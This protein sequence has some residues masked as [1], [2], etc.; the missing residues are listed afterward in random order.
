MKAKIKLFMSA[1]IVLFFVGVFS[2]CTSD[3][4][5][6]EVDYDATYDITY[7]NVDP[8]AAKKQW[9]WLGDEYIELKP[10]VKAPYNLYVKWSDEKGKEALEFISKKEGVITERS[11]N[12]GIKTSLVVSR[13][14]F[15]TPYLYVSSA[16]N[17]PTYNGGLTWI[18]N[19]ISI[20]MKNG[21][22]SEPIQK[23]YADVLKLNESLSSRNSICDYFDCNLKTSYEILQLA[24]KIH[25]R[26]DIEWVEP[27]L[28]GGSYLAVEYY[29]VR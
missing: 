19:I 20:R 13:K 4:E 11:D 6:E 14:Y 15:K 2:S 25:Q 17:D 7:Y 26:N 22:S 23:D 16:Y 29:D 24:N 27:A 8:N 10:Q 12:P 5:I 9:R 1:I 3:D 18:E 28:I 21:A